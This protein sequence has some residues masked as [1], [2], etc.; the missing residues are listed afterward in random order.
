LNSSKTAPDMK[1]AGAMLHWKFTEDFIVEKI[2]KPRTSE[3]K[4]VRK[5][6]A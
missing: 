5:Q 6:E 2:H 1:K 3:L 4:K